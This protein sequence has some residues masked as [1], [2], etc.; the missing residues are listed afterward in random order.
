MG[1]KFIFLIS[2]L[3]F[4]VNGIEG[5]GSLQLLGESGDGNEVEIE[6]F[7]QS[8]A[9]EALS[10]LEK[11]SNNFFARKVSKLISVHEQTVSGKIYH[12]KLELSVTNCIKDPSGQHLEQ[13]SRCD[14]N[15]SKTCFMNFT[16]F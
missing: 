1:L 7:R 12:L 13:I 16:T 10:F 4:L 2:T 11:S 5:T 14:E 3:L 9:Q 6:A 15:P 8:L